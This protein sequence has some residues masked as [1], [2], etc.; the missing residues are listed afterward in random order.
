MGFGPTLTPKVWKTWPLL[1]I[2]CFLDLFLYI[3]LGF[4]LGGSERVQG[5]EM[6]E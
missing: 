1:L 6:L 3:L 5:F 4:R 2:F